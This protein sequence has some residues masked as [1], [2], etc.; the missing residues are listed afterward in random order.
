M[1]QAAPLPPPSLLNVVNNRNG[2]ISAAPREMAAQL[3]LL[4]LTGGKAGGGV[5]VVVGMGDSKGGNTTKLD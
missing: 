1:L 3:W 5:V 2:V 4:H